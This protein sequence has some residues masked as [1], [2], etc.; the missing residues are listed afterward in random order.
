[1]TGQDS[2]ASA[3]ATVIHRPGSHGVNNDL[4]AALA[5]I[6]SIADP[7]KRDIAETM[8]LLGRHFPHLPARA[9]A[10]VLVHG[11]RTYGEWQSKLKHMLQADGS[12]YVYVVGYDRF[13]LPSFICP[14]WTRKRAINR[15][16]RQI[17]TVRSIHGD[18]DIT[19]VAHSFGTYILSKI[20]QEETDVVL[21]RLL[22]CGSVV[23]RAY[24]WDQVASRVTATP[25]LNDVGTRDPWPVMAKNITWGYGPSG[26]F[27]F[28][29]P[30][31]ED[32]YHDFSHSDFFT[33]EH[34]RTYWLPFLK[35]GTIVP[36]LWT[37]TRTKPGWMLGLL[38]VC[39]PTV[40][41]LLGF[42]AVFHARV[43][44]FFHVLRLAL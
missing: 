16:L 28:A 9:H 6:R 20:L 34:M 10:I 2:A 42:G 24:R 7:E 26:T 29:T 14:F 37:S 3:V 1:M 44:H 30:H 35:N 27:G 36:S 22:L 4:Q 40:V 41:G 25:I 15:V 19:V 43:Y 38:R 12:P 21:Y 13:D 32:R 33:E 18:P 8:F 39:S 17:R 11:I 23:P 5:N 31:V